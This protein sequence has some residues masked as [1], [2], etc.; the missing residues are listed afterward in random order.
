MSNIKG[1]IVILLAFLLLFGMIA[2]PVCAQLENFTAP[3]GKAIWAVSMR[4]PP[5]S[6]GTIIVVLSNGD[7]HTGTFSYT[8]DLLTKQA[9]IALDGDTSSTTYTLTGSVMPLYLLL[10]NADNQTSGVRKL[11]LGYGQVEGVWNDYAEA[12]IEKLTIQKVFFNSDQIVDVDYELI[13]SSEALAILTSEREQSIIDFALE[14]LPALLGFVISLLVWIKFLFV[15]NLLLVVA[16]WIAVTM[17]Y[18]AISSRGNIF[19]FY[20]KFFRYQRTLLD[21]I[22]QLWN[23]LIQIISSFRGIFRI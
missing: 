6:T 9:N 4:S 1:R 7:Q 14:I 23:Y 2:S 10:W 19:V 21:F 12:D 13:D 16:L 22:V 3:D 15:D 11:K 17:A 8:G 5:E 20:K 18:S